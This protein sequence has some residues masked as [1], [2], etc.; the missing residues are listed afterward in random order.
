MSTVPHY[1]L[2]GSFDVPPDQWAE[3]MSEIRDILIETAQKR[4]MIT[5][6]DLVSQVD[7]V[8]FN[9]Y[10]QRLFAILGQL[11]V[12]EHEAG[13]P[14]LSVLVVHKHGDMKPGEGFF[15]LAGALGRNTSDVL[16]AWI[17]EVQ[18]VYPHWNR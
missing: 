10:D 17:S 7:A 4:P 14:L 11:S 2:Q 5:Y 6:S 8:S 16:K 1:V 15:E 3:A 9:A 12:A 18:K 13:R